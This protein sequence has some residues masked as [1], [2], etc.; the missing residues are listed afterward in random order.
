MNETVKPAFDDPAG[1][2]NQRFSKEGF[3]FGTEPNAWLREHAD[4]WKPGERVLCVA[5]GEGRN[6]VWL[7]ARGLEVEAF[8]IAEVGI[9]KARQ[10]AAR[11]GV[12]VH[13][14]VADCDG[15]AWREG[16]FDGVAAIFVQFADPPTRTRLFEHMKRALRPGGTLVL[17]GY[18]PKQL[19]YRTGGPPIA[20]H[21]YT[22]AMLRE[23]FADM[24]IV[25]LREYEADV[26]EGTGHL[27]RSALIGMVARR[28]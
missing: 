6:S 12:Q 7:A 3:L 15:Y 14:E 9:A 24:E 25:E 28:R 2:W 17:Q 13:F 4:A 10:L 19:D 27:G 16:A 5:D 21:L 22:K 20:S 26:A 1:T 18:T 8:D 23:A 11:H